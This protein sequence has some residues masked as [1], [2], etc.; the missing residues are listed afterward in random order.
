MDD[1]LYLGYYL[2]LVQDIV[3]REVF[4]LDHGW[5]VDS[6]Q[7]VER[8]YD[9]YRIHN[10]WAIEKI[11][12]AEGS[13]RAGGF[14]RRAD[15]RCFRFCAAGISRR[16]H[17]DFDDAPAEV[18]AYISPKPLRRNFWPP[19]CPLCRREIAAL[20]GKNRRGRARLGGG[21]RQEQIYPLRVNHPDAKAR[22]ISCGPRNRTAGGYAMNN[23]MKWLGIFVLAASL[24][25]DGL[26]RARTEAVPTSTPEPTAAAETDRDA[27]GDRGGADGRTHRGAGLPAGGEIDQN[28]EHGRRGKALYAA[29]A[30]RYA[31]ALSEQWPEAGIFE[32]SMS[33]ARGVL[34]RGR[35]PRER[36]RIFPD[37]DGDGSPEMVIGGTISGAR[38][39]I[40]PFWNLD[41]QGWRAGDARANHAKISIMWISR[42]RK[43]LAHCERGLERRGEQRVVFTMRSRTESLP[44]CRA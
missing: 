8:L 29:Q 37:L 14:F 1:P 31:A 38:T 17:A 39:P 22:L 16:M 44:L 9:D 25:F 24:L 41:G 4:Y 20:R 36:R 11:R 12:P 2:H 3:F 30:D 18:S 33:E 13:Y 27:R 5:K 43:R 32:N 7:K 15:L 19:P 28:R 34:L 42:G 35:C 6:P 26:R 10:T 23:K 40:R 21:A